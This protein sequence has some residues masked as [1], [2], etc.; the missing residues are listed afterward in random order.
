MTTQIRAFIIVPCCLFV[1]WLCSAAQVDSAYAAAMNDYCI[2]PPFVS[3]SPP[4]MVMF[5]VSRDHKLYYEAYNDGVDLDGDG[6]IEKTYD[7]SIEYYGYFNPYKC[8]THTGGS[9]STGMFSPVA[10]NS[11]RF[12]SSGQIS[13]NLLNWLT[14][15]RMDVIRKVMY[16]GSRDLPEVKNVLKR[17]Y[18][19]QD[20]H[21]WGKEYTGRLCYNSTTGVYK[22]LCLT[23][24]DCDS[25]YA[26]TDKS[27]NLLGVVAPTT[28]GTCPLSAV[29]WGGSGKPGLNKMLVVRYALDATGAPYS[30]HAEVMTAIDETQF[31]SG[32]TPAFVSDFNNVDTD[33]GDNYTSVVVADFQVGTGNT[34]DRSR[35]GDWVFAVDGDDTLELEVRNVANGNIVETTTG[36]EQVGWY[37]THPAKGCDPNV[38]GCTVPS[39]TASGTYSL[40]GNTWYRLIVRHVETTGNDSVK[41]WYKLPGG[42]TWR[43]FGY[44]SSTPTLN[45]RAPNIVNGTNDCTLKSE[46]FVTT[47]TPTAPTAPGRHLFCNTTLTD[48][49]TPLLRM[50]TNSNRRIW[51]WA[52][53]E[54]PVC[55]DTFTGGGSASTNRSDYT[56][57]VEV[58]KSGVGT[59]SEDNK[60]ERCRLYGSDYRPIGLFQKYGEYQDD[61]TG[62]S[63]VCSKSMG[64]SCSTD[65][66]CIRDVDN[67]I[68]EGLCFDKAKMYFG[69]MTTSYTK[70]KS[71][72]VLHKNPGPVSDEVN[73]NNGTQQT[74]E[75]DKGNLIISMDRLKVI[76]YD[77][78]SR[79]YSNCGWITTRPIN[80]GECRMWG[81]PIGE[82][83]YESLRYFAGKGAAT[84]AFT[85]TNPADAGVNL[86]KPAWGYN[87]GSEFFQPYQIYPSCSQAFN[88]VLSD[89]NSSYDS[90]QIPGTSY[91]TFDEDTATPTLGLGAVQTVSGKTL[92]N[93]LLDDISATEGV[94][95]N[96]W[97]IGESGGST[98]FI[99]SAK[100]V[101]NLHTIRGICPEEPTKLGSYYAAA[102]AYYGKTRFN[103]ATGFAPVNTFVVALSSP[104]ADIK[105]KAGGRLVNVVP[106]GKS[107]SGSHSI[108]ENCWD[109]CTTRTIDSNGLRL[110]GCSATAFCPTNSLV[111]FYIDDLKYDSGNNIVYAK[112]RINF[113]DVEQGADHDMDAIVTYEICTQAAADANYGSCVGTLPG[114]LRITVN[115]D[116][117]AGSIDQVLGFVISGTQANSALGTLGDGTYLVVKDKDVGSGSPI[118]SLPLNTTLDFSTSSS[119]SSA[120]NL[121]NPLWYAAKWGGFIGTGKPDTTA[122]WDRDNDGVPDSY[123]PVSN[124]LELDE[125]LQKALE[126][127]L[128]RV[129]SGTAASILN[130]SEG[131]GANLL[132]AVFYP[133]KT[134]ENNTQASWIGEIQNLWYYLDPNLQQTSIRED[135]NQN[136]TLELKQDKIAQ[137]EFNPST[138]QTK[139]FRFTDSNGDG[140]ADTPTTTDV[141]EPD[142]VLSLWKA[143]RLLWARD[144]AAN[145][146]TIYTGYN[147]SF[148][149]TPQT[150]YSKSAGTTYRLSDLGS[151]SW[152]LLQTA[153]EAK[154]ITLID[155][156]SG[157]DQP[158]DSDSTAYRNRKVSMKVCSTNKQISCTAD[159]QCPSGGACTLYT[160]EWRLGDIINSTPKLVSNNRLNIY[161]QSSPTGYGDSTYAAFLNTSVY[162]NRGM[163]FV[164]GNDG[165]LHAFKLG[166]LKELDLAFNKA[167]LI[168]ST[169]SCNAAGVCTPATLSDNLGSEIWSFI[170]SQVLP[171]LKYLADP[172]YPHIYYV[173]RTPTI[174][175]ASV[176]LPTS[177]SGACATDYSQCTKA[178]GTWRTI[179]IG[180]MGIGGAVKATTNSCVAPAG[181]VKTPVTGTGYSSYFALDVTD[182]ANPKYLWEF[183]GSSGLTDLGYATTGPV[184]VRI[185]TQSATG[186][187]DHTKNGKWF[188]VFA[189]GPTGPINTSLNEFKGQSDQNLKVFIVDLASGSLIRTI[190]SGLTNAFAGTLSTAAIDTDRSNQSSRG[191]YSDDAVYI[192]YVQKD[193]T[194]TP[195]TW[196]KGGVLRLLTRESADPASTDTTKRWTLSTLISGT[197]PVTTSIT[198]SQ[199]RKNSNLWV[200]F[201]T[202]RNYFKSDD[203]LSTSQQRLYG[204]K[205][206]CYS[207][208]TRTMQTVVPGGTVNDIDQNCSNAANSTITSTCTGSSTALCDQSGDTNTAPSATLP[209]TMAGW[210]I[211]LD[212]AS[213]NLL[214][215]RMIT[216]PIASPAGAVFFTT[217]KPSHDVCQ[218]GGETYIWAPRYDTGGVPPSAAMK[219]KALLQVSTGAFAEISLASAF[220]GSGSQRLEGRRLTNPIFGV[221]PTG[222]GLSLI[223]NPP[224]VKKLLHIREK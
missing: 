73:L 108:K 161:N 187:P 162:K 4:P 211:N 75:N 215:E 60:F 165:M 140:S 76:D 138:N 171:Y 106:V 148:G 223:T 183:T 107:V 204:I 166:V 20:A 149:N 168:N 46:N 53:K 134:F 213:G 170:P 154:A 180:G 147:S 37:G 81:N 222:Q 174:I 113:E 117:A 221:P 115:S 28:T 128:A 56:V 65:N 177:P 136:F 59:L 142:N 111:D 118:A 131:S 1:L 32:V 190:D 21:S 197:G 120:G 206:P 85:Y 129:A 186:V 151:S 153:T 121:K 199:D 22:N 24:S 208:L 64:K 210:V 189:S 179:L 94:D 33:I 173:D 110:S 27:I 44:R 42:T 224:P 167:M 51:E 141:V 172:S 80:E 156:I 194:V 47:G 130:N 92:L 126:E 104:F 84:A 144:L 12:C 9:A 61:G 83:M 220:S 216:D 160:H 50:I 48:G 105:I 35:G 58:C 99:C 181:C 95:S 184:I 132:Q 127:M 207:T 78:G 72:G 205:E 100:S 219:G 164:G 87:K 17:A 123:F 41:I 155:W 19:P 63:K 71:G 79:S 89:V 93:E 178:A 52:S 11:D 55:G 38:G 201:G 135:S 122:K 112:F 2:R 188:A 49:G 116:Y 68:N 146:R 97:F 143:G 109:K 103:S 36:D 139:V 196:T 5:Q 209:N 152:S 30:D 82:M 212:Q 91:A 157:T 39:D 175:D 119:Y 200:F 29:T 203:A 6:K 192:G 101:T 159:D 202:G 193:T 26:C 125:Q 214:S 133:N 145:P 31:L 169:S 98:D 124:P 14:M 45:V 3:Q 40:S 96:N 102:V 74:K 54:A 25:G 67:N 57:Q 16:G 10:T 182:P 114:D 62:I 86:T 90:D 163:A 158:N 195:N 13:G 88:L 176:G 217:F 191:F 15:S 70:N 66:D 7:H 218:F 34:N 69:F 137:F 8:Y 77:Y 150:F 185:A 198:K 23:D 43:V 18:I